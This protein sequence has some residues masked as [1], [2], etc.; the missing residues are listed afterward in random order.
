MALN[1]V[2]QTTQLMGRSE[3]RATMLANSGS[4]FDIGFGG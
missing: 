1:F 2:E 3:R 4:M